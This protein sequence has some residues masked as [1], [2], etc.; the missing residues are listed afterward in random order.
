MRLYV[1]GFLLQ[2]MTPNCRV[3]SSY[4][5]YVRNSEGIVYEQQ[6]GQEAVGNLFLD[7][8]DPYTNYTISVKA[9]NDEGFEVVTNSQWQTRQ[10]SELLLQFYR[11]NVNS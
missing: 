5:A 4:Y 3:I 10:T 11:N 9:T 7:P 8:L 6:Y 1:G 2:A